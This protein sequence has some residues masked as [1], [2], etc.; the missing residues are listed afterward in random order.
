MVVMP[1]FAD[2]LCQIETADV[3]KTERGARRL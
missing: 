1:I 3:K 2:E